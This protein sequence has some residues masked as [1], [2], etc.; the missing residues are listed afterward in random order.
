MCPSFHSDR[1]ILGTH[2]HKHTHT[3][4]KCPPH[5][6]VPATTRKCHGL[7]FCVKVTHCR[8]GCGFKWVVRLISCEWMRP[9]VQQLTHLKQSHQELILVPSLFS[10]SAS[11]PSNGFILIWGIR[12]SPRLLFKN[13]TNPCYPFKSLEEMNWDKDSKSVLNLNFCSGG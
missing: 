1:I 12:F 7:C 2:T 11:N 5:Q 3:A 6:F 8:W 4:Q 13:Y 9:K 10:T